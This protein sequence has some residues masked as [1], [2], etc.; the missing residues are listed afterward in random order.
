[1]YL[2]LPL[3]KNLFY[4]P[5]DFGQLEKKFSTGQVV[6]GKILRALSH[7]VFLLHVRGFNLVAKSNVPLF[8]GDRIKAKVKL[9]SHQIELSLIEVNGHK[10]KV[11]LQLLRNFPFYLRL[12]LEMELFGKNGSLE[13]YRWQAGNKRNG[14]NQSRT[15]KLKLV[16]QSD[17]LATIVTVLE[18]WKNQL[19]CQLWFS[20]AEVFKEFEPVLSELHT[21][22]DYGQ[23]AVV[24]FEA[25]V[26]E[27]GNCL[28]NK[29]PEETK[30]L[31][32]LLDI[33]A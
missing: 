33:W 1:M 25:H 16:L 28:D 22:L 19:H 11:P 29:M 4:L 8:A 24:K 32:N 6:R 17:A 30:K 9:E 2:S 21:E 15:L 26:T 14:D 12:P 5:I 23:F 27:Q 20:S 31:K 18:I 10:V 3:L 7:N 13:I